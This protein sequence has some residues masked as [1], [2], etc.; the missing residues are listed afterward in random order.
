MAGWGYGAETGKR[1]GAELLLSGCH[2]WFPEMINPRFNTYENRCKTKSLK[3]ITL[4][5]DRRSFL[6]W[7]LAVEYMWE[8]VSPQPFWCVRHCWHHLSLSVFFSSRQFRKWKR[9]ISLICRYIF[10]LSH[11]DS[12]IQPAAPFWSGKVNVRTSWQCVAVFVVRSSA[13]F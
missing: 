7:G 9:S 8:R 13:T 4:K 10:I 3:S 2:A 12:N 11:I 1:R 6:S 5:R